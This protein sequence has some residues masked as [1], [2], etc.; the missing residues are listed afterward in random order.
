MQEVTDPGKAINETVA[1]HSQHHR[2]IPSAI[3][4]SPR[5]YRRLLEQIARHHGIG[6]LL[7]G[8]FALRKFLTPFGAVQIMIDELVPDNEI[9]IV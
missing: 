9:Q 2:S 7:I 3:L 4:I 8:C 5:L 1:R 6:N